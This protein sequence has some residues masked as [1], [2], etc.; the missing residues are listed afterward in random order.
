MTPT[1]RIGDCGDPASPATVPASNLE[2]DDPSHKLKTLAYSRAQ[3][4]LY[5]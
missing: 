3:R 4:M 1:T 5:C 2:R